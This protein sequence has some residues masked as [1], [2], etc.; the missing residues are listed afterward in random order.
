[1]WCDW[2]AAI[3]NEFAFAIINGWL[4]A[5]LIAWQGIVSTFNL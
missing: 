1:M 2:F 4:K 5:I 3:Y